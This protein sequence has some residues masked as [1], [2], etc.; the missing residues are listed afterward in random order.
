M[1]QA[2]SPT[3]VIPGEAK[4]KQNDN[5]YVLSSSHSKRVKIS[6]L[7][8]WNEAFLVFKR[9]QSHY[10]THYAVVSSPGYVSVKYKYVGRNVFILGLAR[11]R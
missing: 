2:N 11:L 5:H 3:S 10:Y 7:A 8:Q 1:L 4:L 6:S 9:I